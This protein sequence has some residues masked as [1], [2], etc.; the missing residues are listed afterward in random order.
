MF[1]SLKKYNELQDYGTLSCLLFNLVDL[2]A[3]WPPF[4]KELLTRFTICF[5]ADF[6]FWLLSSWSLHTCYYVICDYRKEMSLREG[7]DELLIN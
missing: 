4:G 1:L 3:E 6:G 2:V 5:W 7:S